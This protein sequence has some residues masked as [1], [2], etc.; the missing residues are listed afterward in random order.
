MQ[1]GHGDGLRFRLGGKKESAGSDSESVMSVDEPISLGHQL[2]MTVLLLRES[3]GTV[4]ALPVAWLQLHPTVASLR[5][6]KL[7]RIESGVNTILRLQ[8]YRN[9][10]F[11][12]VM[13]VVSFCA[14]EEFYLLLLPILF[15]NGQAEVASRLTMIVICGLFMGNTVKD[16]FELPRPGPRVWHPTL[17]LDSTHLQDFG[18]P[19]THVMNAVTNSLLVVTHVTLDHNLLSTPV[20]LT[21]A[22]L[23]VLAMCTS[24]LYLGAHTG[25]DVR[26]GLGLGLIVFSLYF[27]TRSKLEALWMGNDLSG[28]VCVTFALSVVFLLLCPQP[29]PITPTFHQ[30]ALLVGLFLGLVWGQKLDLEVN[31]GE[32]ARGWKYTLFGFVAMLAI[33]QVVKVLIVFM[34]E[35]VFGVHTK[36]REEVVR[37]RAVQS[38]NG[39]K[40]R[41]IRLFT[42]DV[43]LV[44]VAVIK[45][46]TYTSAALWITFGNQ[47]VWDRL[48]KAQ[49]A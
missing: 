16:I 23:Y 24:R 33:R 15:W 7:R 28:T 43:D 5:E 17:N 2:D 35:Q 49:L 1:G 30:N 42:R 39:D 19:S 22:S 3:F 25:T 40:R 41:V 18:F 9:P 6:H 8:H 36:P 45:V 12:F 4:L 10:V 13:Q 26:G 34:L 21:F 29:R 32:P 47:Y 31:L 11:D 27:V 20:A 37:R 44:A 14:E 46:V 48:A 38:A